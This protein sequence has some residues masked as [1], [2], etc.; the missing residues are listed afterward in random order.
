MNT[1][2]PRSGVLVLVGDADLRGH[3]DRAAAAAGV[4]VVAAA[5]PSSTKVWTS[6]SAV[7]VDVDGARRCA[8]RGL[9]RRDRVLVVGPTEPTAEDWQTAISVGAQRV[10]SI[11]EDE[12]RLV[13]E[14]TDAADAAD[15]V[16]RGAVLAVLGGCGG[17]GATVFATALALVAPDPLLVDVDPWG[18]GIE[19]ALGSERDAG[20]RWPDL[21]LGGG[22]VGHAALRAALPSRH[23]VAVLSANGETRDVDPVALAAV[24]DGG[25]RGG[26]TVVCDLPRRAT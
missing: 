6:A 8:Q 14:L 5:E 25:C 20:L 1:S 17:A 2:P 4:R 13:S 18:G 12:G 22:R 9:P 10:L 16:R 21:A 24:L 7:V 3:V 26:G 19:L 11:P 23:G 15:D